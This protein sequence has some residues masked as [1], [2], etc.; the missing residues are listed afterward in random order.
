[1]WWRRRGCDGEEDGVGRGGEAEGEE[2]AGGGVGGEEP[3]VRGEVEGDVEERGVVG[4]RVHRGKRSL[5]PLGW[6]LGRDRG[7]ERSGG[8]EPEVVRVE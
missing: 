7:G 4:G 2:L 6:G 3:P 8:E 5:G 1:M